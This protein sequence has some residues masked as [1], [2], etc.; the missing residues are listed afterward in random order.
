MN[1]GII[2]CIHLSRLVQSIYAQAMDVTP[3]DG[4]DGGD[5]QSQPRRHLHAF[6]LEAIRAIA[7][8][9][10]SIS[11]DVARQALGPYDK[12][13]AE[14]HEAVRP[15]AL[16]RATDF[17]TPDPKSGDYSELLKAGG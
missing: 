15:A 10:Q 1:G 7:E 2:F 6:Q 9:I 5:E 4:Q 11:R 12:D 16:S 13:L 14:I 17:A 3:S 8:P